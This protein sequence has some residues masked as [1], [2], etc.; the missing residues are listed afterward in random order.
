MNLEDDGHCFACGPENRVG[1][2]LVFRVDRENRSAR[3][4]VTL[5]KHFNGWK[6]ITHGGIVSTLLDEAMIYA[7][8]AL[9]WL[10]VTGEITVRFRKPVPTEKQLLVEGFVLEDRRRF[11]TAH[12][13]ITLLDEILAVASGKMLPVKRV[14]DIRLY[15]QDRHDG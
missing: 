8:G 9:G 5:A 14:D 15:L 13:R 10:S 12:G 1:L 2:K 11:I 3:A 7:Y 4:D 6:G